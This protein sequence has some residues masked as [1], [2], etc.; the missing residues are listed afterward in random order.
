MRVLSISAD[1]FSHEGLFF[2]FSGVV[3]RW[4]VGM[5]NLLSVQE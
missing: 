1:F 5:V 3:V 2:L 4:G